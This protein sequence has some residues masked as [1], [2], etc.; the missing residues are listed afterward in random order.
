MKIGRAYFY[1]GYQICSNYGGWVIIHDFNSS[2]YNIYKTLRDAQ[3]AEKKRK[4]GSNRTEPR[5]IGRM[6]AE[7]FINAMVI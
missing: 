4:D 6:T 7:Q 2:D 1:K 3:D 5:I